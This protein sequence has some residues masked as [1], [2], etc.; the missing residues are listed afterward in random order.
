MY[1]DTAFN[2]DSEGDSA[3]LG[4]VGG[5]TALAITLSSAINREKEKRLTS[6]E[7]QN[8]FGRCEWRGVEVRDTFVQAT[9]F[10][11]ELDVGCGID[12]NLWV[13]KG[14][15]VNLMLGNLG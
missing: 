11:I 12:S 3:P 6:D 4:L 1:L 5:A 10:V 13:F 9:K 14:F 2:S 8:Y 15:A 7:I